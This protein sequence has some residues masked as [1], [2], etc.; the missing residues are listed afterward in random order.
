MKKYDIA[1]VGGGLT[2]VAAAVSAARLGRSVTI[3]E[4]S[5]CFGGAMSNCLVYPFMIYWTKCKEERKYLSAGIFTEMNKRQK[6]YNP[7]ADHCN[8]SPEIFKFVFDDMIEEAGVD[9][10][11]HAMLCGVKTEK[12]KITSASFATKSGITEIEADY[13]IDATG[14]GDLF[15]FAGCDYSLGRPEDSKCQPMT[16]CFRLGNV[17]EDIFDGNELKRLQGEYKRLKAENKIKNPR[18]DIL[19]F[20]KLGKGIIHFNTTRVINHNPINPMERSTAEV[21][22]R[23]QIKE[24]VDFLKSSSV[25]FRDSVLIN[26]AVSIGIRESRM[27][28]GKYTLTGEDIVACKKFD[29]RIALGN[30][31]IDIHNPDGSGTSHY[32]FK[33]GEYYSIPFGS[34]ISEQYVNLLVGGRC[35]SADHQAQASVRIMPICATTG[36]A[37][38][39]AAGVMAADGTFTD[40]A[41]IAKIQDVLRKNGAAID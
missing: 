30:Y 14:D 25:A 28:K 37:A 9:Y 24:M 10:L 2:G 1:V 12:N 33:E 40:N 7:S 13:F 29:D 17:D 32:Y 35:I 39:T 38:G 21:E 3:I 19:I 36:E 26:T 11:F 31:D 5:G 23:R 27:L 15:A 16:T 34:L 20:R 18:E 6:E 22:A 4:E 8:F 41:D